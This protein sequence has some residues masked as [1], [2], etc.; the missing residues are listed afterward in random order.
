MSAECLSIFF[1]DLPPCDV[2]PGRL[3]AER[4][5]AAAEPTDLNAR[6]GDASTDAGEDGWKRFNR[7]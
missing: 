4:V 1:Q 2:Y 5:A 6:Y 3:A 7:G